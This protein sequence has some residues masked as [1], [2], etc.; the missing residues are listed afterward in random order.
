MVDDEELLAVFRGEHGP[1][2]EGQAERGD[3]RSQF[4]RRRGEFGAFARLAEL[5]IGNV[6]LMAVWIAEVQPGPGS[7]IQLVVRLLIAERVAPV[8]GEPQL[9]RVRVERETDRVA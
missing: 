1:C 5:G 2:V 3:V 4:L 8:V 7:T 6:S 9:V